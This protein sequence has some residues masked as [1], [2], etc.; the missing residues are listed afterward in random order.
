[1]QSDRSVINRQA[2]R[3]SFS[4][5]TRLQCH[6]DLAKLM[7]FLPVSAVCRKGSKE[8]APGSVAS[9]R[10]DAR[11]GKCAARRGKHDARG[12]KCAARQGKH[13]ARRGK[14]S[15]GRGKCSARQGKHDARGKKCAARR[16]K[17]DARGG[18]CAAV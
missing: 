9:G 1:M 16:G 7:S 14:C 13:D 11:R 10:H 5:S 12:K 2:G 6:D 3:L 17:H 15:S 18:K 8:F 4:V